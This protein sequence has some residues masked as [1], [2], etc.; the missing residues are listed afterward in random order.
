MQTRQAGQHGEQ[1]ALAHLKD[2]G[3]T[4]IARNF[5]CRMGEIDLIMRDRSAL[6]G[7]ILVFVEVRYRHSSSHGGAAASITATKRQRLVRTASRFLQLHRG[8]ARWPSR[9]DGVAIT[10]APKS[11]RISWLRNAFCA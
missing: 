10:G 7:D 5:S 9:F 6:Q 11:P 2:A 3:L 8:Y 4:L 1:L